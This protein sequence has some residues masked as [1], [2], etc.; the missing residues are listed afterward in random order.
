M[1]VF[2][3]EL[4]AM[5]RDLTSPLFTE[6]GEQNVMFS[7]T[8]AFWDGVAGLPLKNQEHAAWHAAG[9]LFAEEIHNVQQGGCR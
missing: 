8:A 6:S 5:A 9:V 2:T 7:N 1:D 4:L 3:S